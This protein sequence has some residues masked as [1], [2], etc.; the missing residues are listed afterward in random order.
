MYWQ[1]AVGGD[2]MKLHQ[3]V[4]ERERSF[5]ADQRLITATDIHG[6][7]TYCNDEFVAI[8]GFVRAQLIGS[9]HNIVRHPD[10]PAVVFAHMW[11]HLKAGKSWM[12][13]VKNR[14][15]N[16]DF[17]WVNA[18]VT[19]ISE[20]GRI[21]GYESVRV[22]P[23]AAQVRRAT[24]LYARLRVGRAATSVWARASRLGREWSCP[25]LGLSALLAA[26]LLASAE[27]AIA[28]AALSILAQQAWSRWNGEQVMRRL[29][30][31]LPEAFDSEL[32]AHA[33]TDLAGG[34]ARVQMIMLSER[35]RMRTVLTRMQDYADQGAA[36]ARRSG[37][38]VEQTEVS[39]ESQRVEA[40]LA[41]TAMHEMAA[42]IAEVAAHV[43]HTADEAHRVNELAG[44]G[45]SEA[46][47]SREVIEK[48][49]HT[50]LGIS[51]AVEDL[52]RDTRSIQQAASMIEAIAEQ[53]NLLALNAAI[54]AARAGE[55]GRGFAVVADE[56]RALASKTQE[57]TR[58]IQ[59][60]IQ[61]LQHGAE[62]A[63]SIA[64]AGSE[65][66]A[67]G[68][69]QV[70]ATQEALHGIGA[71]IDRIHGMS[72]QMAAASEQQSRVAEDISRQI[73]RI[74][75]AAE[76]NA[77]L[78]VESSQVGRELEATSRSL[79][80]LVERFNR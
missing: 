11:S 44:D 64:R 19:A 79:H 40:E 35:A 3:P 59:T 4:T 2:R 56:V 66:A 23:E 69:R 60:I 25:A 70:L 54:E 22:K 26:Y 78:A 58:V 80:A 67:A 33:Y 53:T 73:T 32:I 15:S 72:Q 71:A 68:V 36:L 51:E 27:A 16:G 29:R 8:S 17:Y 9:P 21:I 34:P 48:L 18:Y 52:A 14:C 7:I 13:I 1:S 47:R 10:M 5:P 28:C 76:H 55:Q 39:L 63:V 20:K 77:G 6:R 45:S 46:G 49:A 12:G 61:T 43:H 37:L 62:G 65:E 41:A 75:Q 42:S 74:A 57:S 31:C 24:V 38:L 50:V 30:A